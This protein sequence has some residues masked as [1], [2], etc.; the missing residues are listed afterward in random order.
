[1]Q[2]RSD[3]RLAGMP[4]VLTCLVVVT[5][6]L[7]GSWAAQSQTAKAP[8]LQ[9]AAEPQAAVRLSN[10]T[11]RQVLD[12]TAMRLSHYDP[13][14]K[15]RLVL[16]IRRP[17]P[18][19]EEQ[20]LKQITT[21][22]SPNFRQFLTAEEWNARFAPSAEDEQKIVSWAQSQGL[23]VTNRFANRLLVDVEA[24]AGAIEKALSVTIDNYQVGDEVDFANDRDPQLPASLDGIVTSVMGLNSIQRAHRVGAGSRKKMGPDYVPGPVHAEVKSS[25]G[26]GDPSKMPSNQSSP[27]ANDSSSPRLDMVDT[28]WAGWLIEPGD[29]QGSQA[30]DYTALSALGHC[31]NPHGDSTG[32]PPDSSIVL[33]SFGGFNDSDVQTFFKHYGMAWNYTVYAIDGANPPPGAQCTKDCTLNGDDGEGPLDLEYSTAMANS[34]G[35]VKDTAHVYV[36][37]AVTNLCSTAPDM[38]NFML[39][40]NHAKVLSTSYGW[41][42]GQSGC[43]SDD[44]LHGIFN[45]MTATGWTLVAAAGDD[46]S[47]DTCDSKKDTAAVSVDYPGSD[48]NFVSVGGTRLDLDSSGKYVS[49]ITWNSGGSAGCWGAGGGGVSSVY[50]LPSWQKGLTYLESIAGQGKVVSGSTMRL[51]PDIALNAGAGQYYYDGGQWDSVYGT[52]IGAPELAGFFA[53]EN[54]YLASIGSICGSKGTS[55][56]EPIGNPNPTIYYEA[57]HKN[58]A[59][60]PFYDI[61]QDCNYSGAG[62]ALGLTEYCATTGYDAA[63]GWGSANMLQ[64]AWA[65]NWEVIPARGVPYVTF[66][67]PAINTWYNS[68]QTVNWT[69]HDYVPSG[70]TPGTGI[71]GFTQGWDSIPDDA[72]SKATP[73]S[74]NSFY[75]GPEFPNSHKGCLSLEAGNCGNGSGQGCHTAHVRG[76]NNQG[77]T[78]TGQSSYPGV[79]GPICYDTVAPTIAIGSA[80]AV[81]A[82]GW[83]NS[84][85]TI[86]LSAT[87]PGGKNAS[88]VNKIY[89]VVG[90]TSCLPTALSTCQVYATPFAIGQ[91]VQTVTAFSQ[92]KTGNFSNLEV[93]VF[94]VDVV[95]PVTKAAFSGTLV[96]GIYHSAVTVTLTAT[97]NLSGVKT[98]YYSLDGG[99]NTAYAPPSIEVSSVGARTLKVWSIDVAG[100]TEQASTYSFKIESPTATTM[101]ASP[102]PSA[103]GKPVSMRATVTP[104]LSGTLTGTVKFW[105]GA[106]SLGAAALSGGVASLV[107]N[108]LPMGSLTLH[109]SYQGTT[110]FLA[111]TSVLFDQTVNGVPIAKLSATSLSF[112]STAVGNA[113]TVPVTVTNTGTANLTATAIGIGGTNPTEFSQT[114]NCIGVAIASKGTCTIQVKFTPLAAGN[115]AATLYISDNATGSPQSI[116]LTGTGLRPAVTLTSTSLVFGNVNVGT[117]SASQ[118]VT[119]TNTG[120]APL[121]IGGIAVTGANV[122]SFVFANGCG[123][124]L[125][126]GANC[127]IHGHFAPTAEGSLNASIAI[128]DNAGNSPQNIA[129]SGS[130]SLPPPTLSATSLSFGTVIAGT[131]SASQSVTMTNTGTAALP[132]GSVTLTGANASSFVFADSCGTSLAAGAG[133]TIHG[134]FAPTGPGTLTA[135]IKIADDATN[136]P[137]SIALTGTGQ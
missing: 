136:S 41:T 121:S 113:S 99:A 75:S 14:R 118:S 107:T 120:N 127:T 105:N 110:N 74:G 6:F 97:D 39:S 38:Y 28:S 131:V 3:F 7:M 134:H 46:G 55:A 64:L 81:S 124:S 128:V 43:G 51:V 24:P 12:G 89:G 108:A 68:N 117:A 23:T 114:S 101:T 31:C 57:I 11:A 63:T 5:A 27:M 61:T 53:Q 90:P 132:I 50:P 13:A 67:G 32:S 84:L 9:N 59:H 92:D 29:I 76:W 73:G 26:D 62:L 16:A 35:S 135:T 104:T 98:T 17:H 8:S 106:T 60:D 10:H 100:N 71:A 111:S 79:Y 25:Q 40:D 87:D 86:T 133:C 56:C 48:P 1:M 95:P 2:N 122:S 49:E 22:G 72:G 65:I 80:P 83:L 102:N 45:S 103:I 115:L 21:I 137:Q 93:K 91:G 66:S 37:E 19:E 85:P 58:A 78:T 77:Q 18:A 4:A 44:T 52:S 69:I 119:M 112:P 20:F 116:A 96:G 34:Y 15:L 47:T 129:L 30:Y 42:E 94:Q 125:A 123:T 130:G 36:Y 88:G 109:A 82:S 126:G 54:A 33:A 70:G